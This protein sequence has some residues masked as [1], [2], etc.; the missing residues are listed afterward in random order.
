MTLAPTHRFYA[1]RRTLRSKPRRRR[2][3]H[4]VVSAGWLIER[5]SSRKTHPKSIN[6]GS[7]GDGEVRA[8]FR[9]LGARWRYSHVGTFFERNPVTPRHVTTTTVEHCTRNC[10][11][12]RNKSDKKTTVTSFPGF[13]RSRGSHVKK[14]IGTAGPERPSLV[15]GSHPTQSSAQQKNRAKNTRGAAQEPKN[16]VLKCPYC[17]PHVLRVG[18]SSARY[19]SSIEASRC[20]GSSSV[21]FCV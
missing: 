14:K 11:V 21:C 3:R 15:G 1:G 19:E 6:I 5:V 2:S 8:T 13:Y 9:R 20:D 18:P 4:D 7:S 10:H 12:L 17:H 16:P